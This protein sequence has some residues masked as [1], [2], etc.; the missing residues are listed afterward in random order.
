MG[1]RAVQHISRFPDAMAVVDKNRGA[2][3]VGA[4]KTLIVEGGQL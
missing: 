4:L 2:E 3:R 1:W